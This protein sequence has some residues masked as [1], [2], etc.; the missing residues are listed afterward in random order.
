MS[1]FAALGAGF[2]TWA[3]RLP[4]VAGALD[5]GPSTMLWLIGAIAV[6]SVTGFVSA[7]S[8]AAAASARWTAAAGVTAFATGLTLAGVGAHLGDL[9]VTLAGL[10]VMGGGFAVSD[11]SANLIGTS[12]ERLDGSLSMPLLHAGFSGGALL[13]AAGGVLATTTDTTVGWHLGL[14]AVVLLGAVPGTRVLRGVPTA[15]PAPS[16]RV[17]PPLDRRVVALAVVAWGAMLAEGAAN[18]WL[19][20]AAVHGH[21]ESPRTGAALFL[22]FLL[23]VTASRLGAGTAASRW[24][25]VR[26]NAAAAVVGVAGVLAFTMGGHPVVMGLGAVGWGIGAAVGLPL[27]VSAAA[28]RSSSPASRVAV[29][30]SIGYS[31][32]VVGPLIIGLAGGASTILTGLPLVVVALAVALV[33]GLALRAP[34]PIR[35]APVPVRSR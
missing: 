25:R 19:T 21:G 32:F 28:E 9:V 1:I 20:Y 34:A 30:S 2:A 12:M 3:S 29:V 16:P 11:V 5:L 17:I 35:A 23:A 26:V 7:P 14:V 13:G 33:A 4:D 10:A 6:G 22:A 27:A 15:A 31:A 8:L 18:D 24:G